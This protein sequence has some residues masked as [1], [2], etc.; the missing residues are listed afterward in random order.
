[1]TM[2][3]CNANKYL[4]W[5][6]F[7]H[8]LFFTLLFSTY[9]TLRG[10]STCEGVSQMH[11]PSFVFGFG[12]RYAMI[13]YVPG[14]GGQDGYM[15][16]TKRA[17]KANKQGSYLTHK[18]GSTVSS[19]CPHVTLL[20]HIVYNNVASQYLMWNGRSSAYRSIR[21]QAIIWPCWTRVRKW[22]IQKFIFCFLRRPQKRS[23]RWKGVKYLKY[24]L[25]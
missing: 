8:G 25:S 16:S 3:C 24:W 14:P 17:C 13:S 9:H 2:K 18:R 22:R 10:S 11:L 12:G 7:W 15:R 19:V 1:M 20:G 6:I 5:R 21:S 4:K 23:M